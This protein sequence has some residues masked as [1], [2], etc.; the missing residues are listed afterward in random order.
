MTT[1]YQLT[2]MNPVCTLPEVY[3]G[4]F[5]ERFR[6]YKQILCCSGANFTSLRLKT[7]WNIEFFSNVF[8]LNNKVRTMTEPEQLTV[9]KKGKR[10]SMEEYLFRKFPLQDI[11]V[12]RSSFRIRDKFEGHLEKIM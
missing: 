12:T 11:I 2:S 10:I 8:D 4:A 1:L 6:D 5:T 7:Y 9:T 3:T